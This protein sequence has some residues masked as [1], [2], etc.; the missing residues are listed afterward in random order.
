L[1]SEIQR[2]EG[3]KEE[4]EDK[5]KKTGCKGKWTGSASRVNVQATDEVRKK[6]K[7]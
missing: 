3:V 7:I 6:K 2:G 4:V 5:E 1:C